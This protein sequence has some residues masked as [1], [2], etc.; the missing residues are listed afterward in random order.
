MSIERYFT[1]RCDECQRADGP[2]DVTE[3]GVREC[4]TILRSQGWT[5]WNGAKTLCPDCV[6]KPTPKPVDPRQTDLFQ[7]EKTH[8]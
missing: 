3:I 5:H 4:I 1:V 8:A 7:G 2:N 6:P